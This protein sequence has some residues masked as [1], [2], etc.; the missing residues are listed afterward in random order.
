MNTMHLLR[1]ALPLARAAST[2][3]AS[4]IRGLDI[5]SANQFDRS[6][7]E[8][9][10]KVAEEMRVMVAKQGAS[11]ILKGKL[12][13]TLFME[14]STRTAT[15]FQSA[16]LR[17][18][19]KVVPI[20]ESASSAKKGETFEDTLRV[21][22]QYADAIV[23]RHPTMGAVKHAADVVSIPVL[24]AGDGAGEHPT[25]ALLDCFC[26]H[27]LKG[28]LDG[29]TLTV[30]GDMKFGRTIHSLAV[31]LSNF[32]NVKI[33]FV[34]TPGLRMPAEVLK[35]IEGKVNFTES[36]MDQLPAKI[37]EAD[38]LYATRIQKER[39]ASEEAYKAEKGSYCISTEFLDKS[40]AKKDLIVLHPLPRID[41]I[42]H[43]FDA[44][45]RATYFKQ[46][47]FGMLTRMAL[48]SEVLRD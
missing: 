39:F 24:N 40:G 17:L 48:L 37:A 5:L 7:I 14:P 10:L 13:I 20:N 33:N 42:A 9:V 6:K 28:K 30:V 11:D 3:A 44:D 21:L 1:S 31:L 8:H 38:V 46:V 43:S 16:M 32:K 47:K 15:S 25:Q 27:S 2:K 18:G 29:L 22:E 12:M 23:I 19:G 35:S 36:N 41:E 4:P 26:M 34:S 45:P